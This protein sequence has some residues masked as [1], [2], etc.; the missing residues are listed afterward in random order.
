MS[1]IINIF[2]SAFT[3][4]HR[5]IKVEAGLKLEE[6]DPLDWENTLIYVNGLERTKDYKVRDNDVVTIRQFPSNAGSGGYEFASVMGWILMPITSAII[7]SAIGFTDG[8]FNFIDK[9]IKDAFKQPEETVYDVGQT[10]QIP[11]V[12]GAK[13]RSGANQPIP[14]L[15]G[16]SMYTPITL[17]QNYT[18]ISGKDGEN[19]I[20]HGLYCLGYN[21]IDLK[22]VSLG[23]YK[24]STDRHN[25]T[26]GSL[27]CTNLDKQTITIAKVMKIKAPANVEVAGEN[28]VIIPVEFDGY[29]LDSVNSIVS[30][31]LTAKSY[32]FNYGGLSHFALPSTTC[33]IDSVTIDGDK[34]VIV[35]SGVP[36]DEFLWITGTITLNCTITEKKATTHYPV[37]NDNEG[38]RKGYYQQLEL[39]QGSGEDSAEV[40]LYPQKVV[41][42]NFGTE[43]MHFENVAPLYMQPFSAKYPQKIQLEVQFQ[44][45]VYFEENGD[46]SKETVE[47]CVGYSLDGGVT[48]LPFTAFQG[49]GGITVSNEGTYS[50]SQGSYR[51]TKFEGKKNKMMRFVAEKTFSFNDVFNTEQITRLKN[52]VIEFKIWRKS[53]DKS[54][55]DS[56]HQY[57]CFFSAIRTWCYDYKETLKQ[58]TEEQIETLLPQRPIIEKYRKMTARLGFSIRAGE[59]IS[60][61]IDELN[62]LMESR[63]RF[64]TITEDE[65]GEKTYTWSGINQETGLYETR[66][67][68]NPA[69]LALMILQHPMRGEY[70]YTDEQIDLVS[71][72][73][74]Y[75]WCE[76]TDAGLL[77][78]DCRKYTANG[79]MSR[80]IKTIDL[81]NQILS[82]GHG[83]LV[84]NGNKYGVLY[85]KPDIQP[86]MILNNQNVLEAKNTKN[87]ADDIDGYSCKFIDCLNDYQQ[88]T[89]IFV[90]KDL[91][92]PESP[93][94]KD[95]SE[96]KL[97]SIEVPWITDVK[98]AYRMCM[99]LLACRK[100]R[101]ETWERKLG[102]DGNLLDVGSLVTVQD[103]TIVVGIGDGAQIVNVNT[104]SGDIISID[105]DYGFNV[106]DTTKTYGVKIQHS[107]ALH[108]VSVRTYELASFE[109]TG[110]K[111]TLVFAEPID[112]STVIKPAV[113]DIVSFGLYEKVTTD[114]I[115]LTKKSNNDG[116]FTFVLV[117]YQNDIYNSE[118]GYIPE[119]QTNVT[120]PKDAGT[121]VSEELPPVTLDEVGSVAQAVINEG[122]DEPPADPLTFKAVFYENYIELKCTYN[123]NTL[124]DSIKYF[125]FEIT[126][127]SGE[128]PFVIHSSSNV[129]NYMFKR[130]GEDADGYPE[131]DVLNDWSFRVRAVNIYDIPSEHWISADKDFSV[132][133]TWKIPN[134]TV[135][136]QVIDRTA[137]LTAT[138]TGNKKVYG[139][140]QTA[141]R[142]KRIGNTQPVET[143]SQVTFNGM[144]GVNPD[145]QFYLP[146]FEKPVATDS[147][148]DN[149]MN[150]R[151]TPDVTTLPAEPEN[152][153]KI[154]YIGKTTET[155]TNNKYYQYDS[156]ESEWVEINDRYL[157]DSNKITHTLPLIGQTYRLFKDGN[158]YTGKLT[159]DVQDV[160]VVP[161]NPQENTAI[162]WIG[163][164]RTENPKFVKNGYYLYENGSWEQVFNKALIVPTTYV[165]QIQMINE[166]GELKASNT[167]EV[168]IEAL[169]TNI[170]DIVH[171]H[172]HYKDLYV[173]RLSAISANIGMISQGGMGDFNP[174]T[175]NY[176]ALSDLYPED[177]GFSSLIKKGAFRVGGTDQYFKVTPDPNN[178]DKFDIELK[179]GNITLTSQ[180]D[181]TSFT[182]GT[183][184][185]DS[186]DPNKRLWLTATGIIAQEYRDI[187]TT[188][189]P[190]MQWVNISRVI[191]DAKGNMIITNSDNP[192]AYGFQREGAIYH[193]DNY[194]HPEYEEVPDNESPTNP[195]GIVCT[196]TAVPTD[197][198]KEGL[199]CILYADSSP[200]CIKGTVQKNLSTNK[201]EGDIVFFSKAEK[202]VIYHTAIDVEGNVETDIPDLLTGYNEAMRET[203]TEEPN[204]T[205][206]E[207]LGLTQAQINKGIF[208]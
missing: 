207:Y 86:V 196:G 163:E 184:I 135:N 13:N 85:D 142:I 48:Y 99:Y 148:A 190:N 201:F 50:D 200:N 9:S 32:K 157:S 89:Q 17:A 195:E 165:Y 155:V 1:A 149:E 75:E 7:S 138:Y 34:I 206:G 133:G 119:F 64:C 65:H 194:E 35:A 120:S 187:G 57:K 144:L 14:L 117:P 122:S 174:N 177:S 80:Q 121:E 109:T 125:E 128:T 54:P 20:F 170:A 27:D 107:D 79:V 171:S 159:K 106:T 197:N 22:S 74:F 105:V 16:E 158:V 70:A 136:K 28:T 18:T 137:I 37:N 47:L 19:Q 63:A 69:S 10:E 203:S 38:K 176:W 44:N 84:I 124:T 83:K 193:F 31:S 208:Y 192:P 56:K 96:Y 62:V 26:S 186:S 130:T 198:D 168:P 118:Y 141:V 164:T 126:K 82:C 199:N 41:Q 182:A 152:G 5:K 150:Y 87:F 112:S 25:G 108:G 4:E 153:D 39:Q 58:Y 92:D 88:D 90:P 97:E 67:T 11:T 95:P 66:P 180:G 60:G 188:Q 24:L 175:G 140:I 71:F 146:E 134:I 103:D 43:L 94:Y 162:H 113:N 30:Q 173:E 178:P 143:E 181:G 161:A 23:I 169:C 127:G 166:A 81:V 78:S 189:N 132:Y 52:N 98:R 55:T 72:G 29:D 73:Q 68:N 15:L 12:S 46:K 93:T 33:T 202:I 114:A 172:E 167:V 76:Q 205:V 40:S 91:T 8:V 49:S 147:S 21:D 111:T 151:L 104:S 36:S 6:V 100:L 61:T 101:P 102:V 139:K 183:Y 110:T 53:L 131:S 129:Y 2:D 116:T 3:D 45:L 59:E 115:V 145:S 42:E 160:S 179:A 204:K 185:Y 191:I 156:T 123:G 51:V 154:H 77:N